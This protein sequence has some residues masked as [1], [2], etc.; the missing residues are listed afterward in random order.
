MGPGKNSSEGK[1][2]YRKV[3]ES[4]EMSGI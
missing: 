3:K 1:A 4:R 2:T